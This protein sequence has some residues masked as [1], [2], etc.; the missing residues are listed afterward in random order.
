[1]HNINTTNTTTT[2]TTTAEILIQQH[3][4]HMRI[5]HGHGQVRQNAH[6]NKFAM[7]DWLMGSSKC[8]GRPCAGN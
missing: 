5:R 2:T 1:M 4:F 3:Q 7:F 8:G 6:R